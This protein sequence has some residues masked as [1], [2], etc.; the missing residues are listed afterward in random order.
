MFGAAATGAVDAKVSGLTAPCSCSHSLML[1]TDAV[2]ESVYGGVGRTWST[3]VTPRWA[4]LGCVADVVAATR[5][6]TKLPKLSFSVAVGTMEAEWFECHNGGAA[7][8]SPSH[9]AA[10][11]G[12]DDTGAAMMHLTPIWSVTPLAQAA[13]SENGQYA[14]KRLTADSITNSATCARALARLVPQQLGHVLSALGAG[15][16]PAPKRNVSVLLDRTTAFA[17]WFVTLLLYP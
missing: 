11:R 6:C 14:S 10:G 5:S 4:M 9:P 13:S 7:F 12:L 3:T 16:G 1:P 8:C 2:G 17:P 15:L